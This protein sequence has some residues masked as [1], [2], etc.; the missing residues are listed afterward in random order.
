ML[1]ENYSIFWSYKIG[2]VK[3]KMPGPSCLAAWKKPSAIGENKDSQ[4][5]ARLNDRN[6][7]RT[8]VILFE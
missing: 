3:L 5:K 4:T 1:S 6:R 7:D 8:Q 2:D